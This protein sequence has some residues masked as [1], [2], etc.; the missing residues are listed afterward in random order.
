[1][2]PEC[3][4]H[5]CPRVQVGLRETETVASQL[6]RVDR[7]LASWKERKAQRLEQ[8]RSLKVL[9]DLISP[10]HVLQSMMFCSEP[11]SPI[12]GLEDGTT[13]V[14]TNNPQDWSQRH[15]STVQEQINALRRRL[16]QAKTPD[17]TQPELTEAG[18]E[19]LQV[20]RERLQVRPG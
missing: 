9:L 16:G 20:A 11:I 18:L 1:M 7:V 17:R 14:S 19:A 3:H 12:P 10:S 6:R 15:R 13:G 5:L 8:Y 2:A 4:L